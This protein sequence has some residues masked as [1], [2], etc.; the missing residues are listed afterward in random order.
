MAK[1]SAEAS[2]EPVAKSQFTKMILPCETPQL[3]IPDVD[4]H[5]IL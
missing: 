3:D 5:H 2:K 4:R 1:K